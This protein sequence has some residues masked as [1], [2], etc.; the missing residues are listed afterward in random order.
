MIG[1]GEKC[2]NNDPSRQLVARQSLASLADNFSAPYIGYYLAALSGSGLLQGVL[3]FSVNSLPTLSQV[4]LGS[5]IDR[6]RRYI[7]ILLATS[8]TASVL[9]ILVSLTLDPV[10]LV[11]LY[12]ARAVVVGISG[13]ALTAFI[14]AF[15]ASHHRSRVL[16][17]I[18]IASQITALLAFAIT[19]FVVS[20]TIDTLRIIFIV[21]GVI[22]FIG[23]VIWLNLLYLDSCVKNLHS[24]HNISFLKTFEIILKNK[25]F[26]KFDLAFTGY[27]F[28]M[29]FAWPYFAMAQRYLYRM[30]ISDLAILNIIGTLSAMISQY[31]LMRIIPRVDLK[32]LVIL[33]RAGFV[34]PPLF[35]AISPNIEYIYISNVIIGPFQAISNVVISLYVLEI[36]YKDLQ[37]SHLAFLNF[38]QGIAG[39][40]GSLLGGVIMDRLISVW[41]YDGLRIGFAISTILRGVMT[42]P[43]VKIDSVKKSYT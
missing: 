15:Y 2:S 26:V 29:S 3:Q 8:I 10:T 31:M 20:P 1:A 11:G 21:S 34:T 6:L 40:I 43:F 41:G 27:I 19:A 24:T 16:S 38:S 12:T 22:S 4:L 35:Y 28:V 36:S 18:T 9:W 32:K 30:S 7:L 39:A 23:S 37:A 33:S 42:I 14:G 5:L 13:L 25:P 17:L